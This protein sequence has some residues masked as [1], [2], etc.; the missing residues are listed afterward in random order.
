MSDAHPVLHIQ[1]LSLDS[2]IDAVS[3]VTTLDLYERGDMVVLPCVANNKGRKILHSFNPIQ[4]IL[5]GVAQG[6]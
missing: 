1:S 2:S 4:V 6:C 3:L 5:R